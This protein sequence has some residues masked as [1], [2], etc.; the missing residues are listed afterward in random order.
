MKYCSVITEHADFHSRIEGWSSVEDTETSIDY[1][2]ERLNSVSEMVKNGWRLLGPP[3]HNT[4]EEQEGTI[5]S[6]TW[7]LFKD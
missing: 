3:V 5:H 1:P 2:H 6:H 7:W 4:S